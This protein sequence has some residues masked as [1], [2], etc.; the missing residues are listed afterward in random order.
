MDSVICLVDALHF[1][2]SFKQQEEVH[3][4]VAMADLMLLNKAGDV[5]EKS[6]SGTRE[7]LQ[8]MNPHAEII[9]TDHADIRNYRLL[10]RHAYRTDRVGSFTLDPET[11][12]Q[13]GYHQTGPGSQL[14]ARDPRPDHSIS[15]Y[16]FQFPGAFDIERFS[17]WI[18]YFLYINQVNVFRIKG[19]L[20]FADN[21]QKMI[22]QTVRSSYLLEDW[23]F[24]EVGEERINRFIFIGKDIPHKDIR[25]ALE[26]LMR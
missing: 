9:L 1:E 2:H 25:E 11:F 22:L 13:S 10:D 20:N 19:I 6:L 12:D 17:Y 26:S 14:L 7:V 3:R 21:P 15:S 23:E 24:W 18:E 4:Q 5:D 16:S 8:T